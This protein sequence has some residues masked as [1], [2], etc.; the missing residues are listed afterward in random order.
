M[1]GISEYSTPVQSVRQE[2]IPLPLDFIMQAGNAIQQR[3]DKNTAINDQFQTGLA[4]MEALAPGHKDY[5]K[6]YVNQYRTEQSGL[7]DKF[8]NNEADPEY[9]RESRR[10]NMKYAADPNLKIIQQANELYKDKVKTTQQLLANN[11]KY[12]D[13]NP[14]FNGLDPNGNLSSN[15]GNVRATDFD[16][17]I[18]KNFQAIG[19][20]LE[21][22]KGVR[23]S[24]R[25]IQRAQGQYLDALDGHSNNQDIN[26]AVSYYKQQGYTDSGAKN[27][28]S[29]LI[30]Q[31]SN[32]IRS[33]KDY[34]DED[35]AYKIRRDALEDARYRALHGPQ[36]AGPAPFELLNFDKPITP[37]DPNNSVRSTQV[38]SIDK[39]LDNL[40]EKGNLK[41]GKRIVPN[42]P[43]NIKAFGKDATPTTLFNSGSGSGYGSS[44]YEALSVNKGVDPTESKLVNTAKLLTGATG[45]P[46]AV[47]SKYKD[48]VNSF[49]QSANT[50]Y[51]TDNNKLNDAYADIAR[52]Q[53]ATG[54]VYTVQN[55]NL[56]KVTDSKAL[57]NVANIKGENVAGSS[58]KNLGP[59]NGYTQF[60]DKDGNVYYTPL[61]KQYQQQ[62]AGS[63]SVENFIQDFNSDN[64]QQLD[65]PIQKGKSQKVFIN[66]D[67]NASVP[68]TYSGVSG[69][70][71]PFK[72]AEGGKLDGGGLFRYKDE[73]G[74]EGV[75]PLKLSEIERND[76]TSIGVRLS[77]HNKVTGNE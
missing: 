19:N 1:A 13:S 73:N 14:T 6:N 4:S 75:V 68:Y 70:I 45:S 69:V 20:N 40:D 22:F 61:P 57:A 39:V 25:N 38:T 67:P 17:S 10:I 37:N 44:S 71:T 15:V 23:T 60:T 2:Y 8:K 59:L 65:L 31:G 77:N 72:T 66:K 34:H 11:K 56:K 21:G 3:G 18:L 48:L 63:K 43:E 51:S 62:F 74:R 76:M 32:Y 42:T 28:V 41:N 7:L 52:R 50:L 35:L 47:L 53:V 36:S 5:L 16:D 58:S 33:E 26:D 12:I 64:M 24:Q 27:A 46:K 54:E 49:N 30:A 9:I 29:G 55:G